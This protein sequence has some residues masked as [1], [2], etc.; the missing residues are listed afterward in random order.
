MTDQPRDGKVRAI[1]DHRREVNTYAE[2]WHASDCVLDRG[3]EAP[4]GSAWQYL[5]SLI[6]TA[7]SFEAYMNHVGAA[8][9]ANWRDL[10]VLAPV[11]KLNHLCLHLGVNIG[12]NGERPL[13]TIKELI[14]IRNLLAHGKSEIL[15]PKPEVK[16]VDETMDKLLRERP[17]TKWEVH[18]TS[19][20][21]ALRAREDVQAVFEALQNARPEPKDPLFDFGLHA[22]G[23]SLVQNDG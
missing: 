20:D 17:L 12:G 1:I 16:I 15:Q 19:P 5:A 23:A 22:S 6:L 13:Q 18:I 11:A 10:E 7:F 8:H 9:V 2:L 3:R 14:G 21:F 4:E